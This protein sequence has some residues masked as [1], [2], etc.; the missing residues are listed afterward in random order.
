MSKLKVLKLVSGEEI[1]GA[2]YDGREYPDLST[3][4]STDNL[5]FVHA[6]L[7]ITSVY[8]KETRSH[9][10]Y[11]S[12]WIPAIASEYFPIDKS[13]II[14]IGNSTSQLEEHYFNLI[15]ASQYDKEEDEIGDVLKKHDFDD[16]DIQ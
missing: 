10:I 4:Y 14:T 6:P 7:K 8:H 2:V 16:D 5:V 11:L 13:K 3:E 12:D 15:I 9:S 1:M